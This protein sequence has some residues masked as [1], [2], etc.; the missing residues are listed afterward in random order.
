M[1]V[2]GQVNVSLVVYVDNSLHQ[3]RSQSL[4]HHFNTIIIKIN[5]KTLNSFKYLKKI[6]KFFEQDGYPKHH[7]N[8][9]VPEYS[10]IMHAK[11]ELVRKTIIQNPFKSKYFAWMNVGIF[12]NVF[13]SKIFSMHLSPNFI[14][15]SV[16]YSRFSA[17]QLK[18]TAKEIIFG[19]KVWVC[20]GYFIASAQVMFRWPL[21]CSKT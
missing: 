20:E 15:S 7:P 6:N 10:C 3:M 1:E 13:D 21:E 2:Y 12:K 17:R 19:N 4:R 8:T 18:L 14:E 5:R 16:A 11:Y 9:V